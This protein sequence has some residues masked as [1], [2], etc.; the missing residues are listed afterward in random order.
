MDFPVGAQLEHQLGAAVPGELVCQGVEQFQ[1][2][3][4]TGPGGVDAPERVVH[5]PHLVRHLRFDACAVHL[6]EQQAGGAGHVEVGPE[7]PWVSCQQ[8]LEDSQVCLERLAVLLREP[9]DQPVVDEPVLRARVKGFVLHEQGEGAFV[10]LA[11]DD[12]G[13]EDGVNLLAQ[14]RVDHLVQCVQE[15]E[16]LGHVHDVHL[17]ERVAGNGGHGLLAAADLDGPLEL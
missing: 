12:H 2:G 3:S 11:V 7:R 17:P 16:A 13:A 4:G 8:Q 9:V 10:C 6:R 5:V 14:P 1:H 15:P